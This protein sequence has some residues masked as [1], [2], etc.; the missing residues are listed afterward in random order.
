MKNTLILLIILIIFHR[1]LKWENIFFFFN[2]A[3]RMN[4]LH[5]RKLICSNFLRFKKVTMGRIN[6]DMIYYIF[7][8]INSLLQLNLYD[9]NII[10]DLNYI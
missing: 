4:Y 5:I 2:C 6:L 1:L 10:F 9:I 7:F 8:S 3:A